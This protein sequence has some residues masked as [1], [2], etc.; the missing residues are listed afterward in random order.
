MFAEQKVFL[1][2]KKSYQENKLNFNNYY[3]ML[4]SPEQIVINRSI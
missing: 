3:S 2:P 1:H 4:I